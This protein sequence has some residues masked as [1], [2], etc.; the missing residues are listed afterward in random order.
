MTYVATWMNQEDI[1]QTEQS[2]TLYDFTNAWTLNKAMMKKE[3][4]G[5]WTGNR[6]RLIKEYKIPGRQKTRSESTTQQGDYTSLR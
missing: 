4:I 3:L 6:E 2:H 5:K 1:A